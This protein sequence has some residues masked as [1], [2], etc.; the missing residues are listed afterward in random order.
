[1]QRGTK[2]VIRRVIRLSTQSMHENERES[3]KELIFGEN[4]KVRRARSCSEVLDGVPGKNKNQDVQDVL[5]KR[6]TV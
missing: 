6:R 4:L 3:T 2:Q 1:M 5:W